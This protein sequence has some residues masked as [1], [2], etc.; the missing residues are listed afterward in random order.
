MSGQTRRIVVGI[1]GSSGPIYGIRTL[2]ALRAA[3]N[4]EIHLILTEA[5]SQTIL[6]E[7]G[8]SPEQVLKLG[9]VVHQNHDL[10]AGISSGSFTTDGMIIAP[11]SMRSLA[12]IAHSVAGNLLTRAA[13]VHL[14]ER[15]RLILLVRET[16]LHLGHLRNMVLATEA[17]AIILPPIPAFYHHPQTI[18]DIINHSVG[19]ALDLLSIPHGLFKRWKSSQD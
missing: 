5:A 19:K 7:T 13:D 2:E 18:D 15:R 12:E 17:G 3:G 8:W 6:L 11:C 10:A 1:S 14:K 16:P 9:D 4:I